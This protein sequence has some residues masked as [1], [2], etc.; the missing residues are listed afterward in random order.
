MY[1]VAPTISDMC[2]HVVMSLY[3]CGSCRQH[4][5]YEVASVCPFCEGSVSRVLAARSRTKGAALI[6]LLSA[7]GGAE[8]QSTTPEPVTVVDPEEP[9]SEAPTSEEPTPDGDE[10]A[11]PIEPVDEEPVSMPE[12]GVAPDEVS[13]PPENDEPVRVPLYGRPAL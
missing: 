8:E 4:F 10:S 13:V 1:G 5:D 9:T 6:A 7:C 11:T 2:Y 3:R 12:Y